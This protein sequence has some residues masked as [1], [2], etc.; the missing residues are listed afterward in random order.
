M[1]QKLADYHGFAFAPLGS[2]TCPRIVIEAKLLG[3]DL[4]LNKN[5]LHSDE[6]WFT[7]TVEQA[8]DYLRGRS[9]VFW[10]V[11]NQI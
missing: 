6:E 9:S 11:L 4:L 3:C 2:D 10:S 1:L 5:V 7:G 8:E